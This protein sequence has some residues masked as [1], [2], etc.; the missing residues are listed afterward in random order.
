MKKIVLG[1][2][3]FIVAAYIIFDKISDAS[4]KK[5][6]FLIINIIKLKSVFAGWVRLSLF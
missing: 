1:I 3:V 4:L 6:Q 2:L 5:F